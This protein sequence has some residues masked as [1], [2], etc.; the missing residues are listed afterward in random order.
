MRVVRRNRDVLGVHARNL[1]HRRR[2]RPLAGAAFVERVVAAVRSWCGRLA[3]LLPRNSR[4]RPR[5]CEPVDL[6]CPAMHPRRCSAGALPFGR[7]F[8]SF[9][10]LLVFAA[11]PC[12]YSLPRRRFFVAA[13]TC[14]RPAPSCRARGCR[15]SQRHFSP[16]SLRLVLP[17][18]VFKFY[19]PRRASFVRR[20]RH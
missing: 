6:R 16:S 3:G 11:P 4:R 15:S 17:V 2:H 19:E 8:G 7:S 14:A 10:S 20:F 12:V 1:R 18:P 9:I 13:A 5:I